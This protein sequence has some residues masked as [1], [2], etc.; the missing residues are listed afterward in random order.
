MMNWDKIEKRCPEAMILLDEWVLVNHSDVPFSKIF[1]YLD[2]FFDEQG[3]MICVT[4]YFGKFETSIENKVGDTIDCQFK[5]MLTRIE[6][7]EG[8]FTKA[9]EILEE[10]LNG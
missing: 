4:P 7:E 3:I 1:Y 8:A 2:Y 10:K 6:A 9:F 5:D